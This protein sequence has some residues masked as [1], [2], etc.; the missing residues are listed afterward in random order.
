VARRTLARLERVSARLAAAAGRFGADALTHAE[1]GWAADASSLAL[2]RGLAGQRWIAWRERP[3]RLDARARRA[4]AR[5]LAALAG[6]Q[7]A[8]G[9]RLRRLW[10]ARSRPSNYEF[11][12]RRLARAIASTTRAARA[13]EANRPPAPPG[14]HEGFTPAAVF[15]HLKASMSAG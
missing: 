2:R 12:G 9:A 1:L 13:L 3:A 14:P 5:E 7:R 4:L 15:R 11:T 6:E 10:L 8:L